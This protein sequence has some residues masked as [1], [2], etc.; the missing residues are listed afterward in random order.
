[1]SGAVLISL[2]DSIRTSR[3]KFLICQLPAGLAHGDAPT[4]TA[5]SP[6]RAILQPAVPSRRVSPIIDCAHLHARRQHRDER[7]REIAPPGADTTTKRGGQAVSGPARRLLMTEPH[8]VA[9]NSAAPSRNVLAV[10]LLKAKIYRSH[11]PCKALRRL[12]TFG[13]LSGQWRTPIGSVMEAVAR[14]GD[15]S[16]LMAF[17]VQKHILGTSEENPTFTHMG[18]VTHPVS[19]IG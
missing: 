11:G 19:C 8:Q 15:R 13:N 16:G 18:R 10:V 7:W 12:S 17:V 4:V 2:P 5:P 14:L 9:N 6:F 3:A 1:M